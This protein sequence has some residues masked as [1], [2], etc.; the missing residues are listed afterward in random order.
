[1]ILGSIGRARQF[2]H[3]N[4]YP[5]W[6]PDEC[7]GAETILGSICGAPVGQL[8]YLQDEYRYDFMIFG[9]FCRFKNLAMTINMP[10]GCRMTVPDR[11]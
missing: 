3:E 8:K 1:M 10:G 6:T 7:A 5:R 11:K 4:Q 9:H 2:V